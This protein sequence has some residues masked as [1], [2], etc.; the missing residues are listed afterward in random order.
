M[1]CY[2]CRTN[3]SGDHIIMG[4]WRC[5]VCPSLPNI[6]YSQTSTWK[7]TIDFRIDSKNYSWVFYSNNLQANLYFQTSE[8]VATTPGYVATR[9]M[10]I[11]EKLLSMDKLPD[12]TANNVVEKT[13]MY[14]ALL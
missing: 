3:I 6:I 10:P 11:A 14:L 1:I 5:P 12:I 4:F 9:I 7:Q 13:R 2:F 8:H